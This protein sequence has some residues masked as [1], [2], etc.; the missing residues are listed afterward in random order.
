MILLVNIGN[1]NTTA[2]G[3]SGGRVIRRVRTPTAE[4][5]GIVPDA[6]I[7]K[8]LGRGKPEGAILGSTVPSRVSAWRRALRRCGCPIA[9][10]E[11]SPALDPGFPVPYAGRATL[12]ADRLADVCG[13]VARYGR[14]LIVVDIG[15]AATVNVVTR[16]GFTGG[17]IAPGPSLFLRAMADGTAQLPR[18]R[19][20]P[21]SARRIGR[22]TEESMRIGATAGFSAMLSG[23]IRD[24]RREAGGARIPVV[25][26][27]GG[28][29]SA[30]LDVPAPVAVDDDLTL[31]GLAH[32]Y[33]LNRPPER[34]AP[35]KS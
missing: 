24:V 12:G 27:G 31:F 21:M 20:G 16:K 7:R 15:T 8:V 23:L 2:A 34:L 25:I 22:T 6:M 30:T 28:A 33:A 5:R 35:S 32:L 10:L 18:L 14:P 11:V 1:T 19:P 13:G 26:T 29:K 17:V 9:P 3:F 4:C